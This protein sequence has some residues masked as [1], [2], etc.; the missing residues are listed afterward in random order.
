MRLFLIF[1]ILLG[2]TLAVSS[3][4]ESTTFGKSDKNTPISAREE[5]LLRIA[6]AT[7]SSGDFAAS[8]R[9]YKQAVSL[10]GN[11]VETRIEL[12]EFYKRQHA[13]KWAIA[14]LKEAVALQ[15]HNME[16]LRNLANTYINMGSPQKAL[17]LLDKAIT[18]HGKDALLYN[19]KGVALDMQ[20]R[21]AEAQQAYR[22]AL[23]IN[24]DDAVTFDANLSMSYILDG[25]YDK[26]IALLLPLLNSPEANS[27]I[28]QNLALAYGLNG[29]SDKALKFG[30]KDLS[31]KEA[32]DNLKFY[33]MVAKTYRNQAHKPTEE[34][35]KKQIPA[36]ISDDTDTEQD[37][38]AK[39]PAAP[40]V[41][42][43]PAISS[44]NPRL[45]LPTLKPDKL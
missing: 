24:P 20:G 9:L 14:P 42:K 37:T 40:T 11:N 38:E 8:E 30:L 16:I 25:A 31:A 17:E 6:H 35:D 29:E 27:T 39:A 4:G 32:E 36:A 41:S 13:D 18:E 10:S 7:E 3:C 26:A 45:P 23:E 34:E 22:M 28:R 43:Q 21:Y 19:S 2:L 33:R 15:P 1:P 44:F 5:G 12:A